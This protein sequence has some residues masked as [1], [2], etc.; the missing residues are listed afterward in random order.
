MNR[1]G[2]FALL[3]APFV[4]RLL[5]KQEAAQPILNNYIEA[6]FGEIPF[7]APK[8]YVIFLNRSWAE[9]I[10]A[11]FGGILPER[12]HGFKIYALDYDEPQKYALAD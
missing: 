12:Y 10:K 11:E 7:P 1:R 6:V 3:T 8:E 4:A 5:P 2:F 9:K